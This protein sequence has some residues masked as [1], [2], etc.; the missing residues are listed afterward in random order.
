MGIIT[1]SPEVLEYLVTKSAKRIIH[2]DWIECN[3]CGGSVEESGKYCK[4]C[5]A[6]FVE[7]QDE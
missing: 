7:E 1:I 4:H 6:K 5:G 2:W 3:N